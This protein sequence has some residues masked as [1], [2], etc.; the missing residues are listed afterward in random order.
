LSPIAEERREE[1]NEEL[2]KE[3]S[4]IRIGYS[5]ELL[6]VDFNQNKPY[7]ERED[8]YGL[9]VGDR[10]HDDQSFIDEA[11]NRGLDIDGNTIKPYNCVWY[12]GSDN[13]VDMLTKAEFLAKSRASST[14]RTGE[15]RV[16]EKRT[17]EVV[18]VLR[19]RA[20]RSGQGNHRARRDRGCERAVGAQRVDAVRANDD[21]G[22]AS[23]TTENSRADALTYQE[24]EALAEKHGFAISAFDYTDSNSLVDLVND[25]IRTARREL[26]PAA[27]P[28]AVRVSGVWPTGDMNRAGLKALAE[29]HHTRGD[30]V[31]AVFLAMCAAAPS[32]ADERAAYERGYYD[33][34][35]Y[36]PSVAISQQVKHDVQVSRDGF[37]GGD[38]AVDS[39]ARDFRLS[40][41]PADERAAY[42]IDAEDARAII[43]AGHAIPEHWRV[44]A[45][46]IVSMDR[47]PAK[48]EEAGKTAVMLLRVLLKDPHAR[49]ASA[50]ETADERA[51]AYE[52]YNKATGHAIV[53]YSRRTYVGHLTEEAGYE[54][55]PLVYARAASPNETG[56]E[57]ATVAWMHA[58]DPRDCISD[59]K[60]RDMIEHAGAPGAR[61]AEKYSIALGRIGVVPAMAAEAVANPRAWLLTLGNRELITRVHIGL[62]RRRE[63]GWTVTPLYAAPQPAQ[64]D[65]PA[66]ARETKSN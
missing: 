34:C 5:G 29:F 28:I 65:A 24:V 21:S 36:G 61:L 52:L 18:R 27:A 25:A 9:T 48:R 46:H 17:E 62:D 57:G 4:D 26:Q 40:S 64:A 1:Q 37:S 10:G 44:K 54:A 6:Y 59:A 12:N 49:A 11:I 16:S 23:M 63:E 32:P 8:I 31:D 58:D 19:R 15:K 2:W 7:H 14:N 41:E 30:T 22:A 42:E 13:P 43:D 51:V 47:D 53:D 45:E 20:R 56:A 50:N 55:R 3:K 35:S 38:P 60:K 39:P 33:G 66:E